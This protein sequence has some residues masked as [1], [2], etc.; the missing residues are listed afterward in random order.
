M[1]W[2]YCADYKWDPPTGSDVKIND[3][4]SQSQQLEGCWSIFQQQSSITFL[5]NSW[6]CFLLNQRAGEKL[7]VGGA[8]LSS[9]KSAQAN[10]DS[11]CLVS[12]V[13]WQVPGPKVI[14]CKTSW[15]LLWT[16]LLLLYLLKFYFPLLCTKNAYSTGLLEDDFLYSEAHVKWLV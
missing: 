5:R 15:C 12:R 13:S 3:R 1:R 10:P 4:M 6:S 14:P 16:F 8:P 2:R 7:A 11:F 9:D